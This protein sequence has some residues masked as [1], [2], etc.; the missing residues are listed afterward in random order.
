[1]IPMTEMSEE[2]AGDEVT[3]QG[4]ACDGTDMEPI[5]D[6]RYRVYLLISAI[7]MYF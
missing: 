7:Y 2:E 3:L 1:M 6:T 4:V 5:T